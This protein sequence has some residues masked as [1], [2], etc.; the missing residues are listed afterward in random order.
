MVKGER[1][2]LNFLT[3]QEDWGLEGDFDIPLLPSSSDIEIN[4]NTRFIPFNLAYT[5]SERERKLHSSLLFS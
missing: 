1:D 5:V 4:K 2:F 3:I